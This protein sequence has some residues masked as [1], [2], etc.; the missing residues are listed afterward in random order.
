[1]ATESVPAN[2]LPSINNRDSTAIINLLCIKTHSSLPEVCASIIAITVLRKARNPLLNR[3]CFTARGIGLDL[4]EAM[5]TLRAV[6]RLRPD[7]IDEA[8]IERVLTAAT[9]APTGKYSAL[10]DH[11]SHRR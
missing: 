4:Y 5:S 9:W 2:V 6:R 1:M 3:P 8:V 11:R 10:A 7:P